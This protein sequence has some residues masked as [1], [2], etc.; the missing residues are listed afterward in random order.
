MRYGDLINSGS[1]IL[2]MTNVTA[3]FAVKSLL[4]GKFKSLMAHAEMNRY[5]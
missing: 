3:S 5:G 2:W 4:A 1:G